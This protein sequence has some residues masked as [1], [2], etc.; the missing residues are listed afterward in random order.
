MSFFEFES[1]L[2]SGS[3]SK[4]TSAQVAIKSVCDAKT[5]AEEIKGKERLKKA[6][7]A[8]VKILN[9]MEKAVNYSVFRGTRET[10][11]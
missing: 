1:E 9:R 5:D 3:L 11:Q 7:R 10:L 8:L 4:M 6:Q 2:K